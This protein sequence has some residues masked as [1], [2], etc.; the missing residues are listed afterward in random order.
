MGGPDQEIL[1]VVT[2]KKTAAY[3]NFDM[4][5]MKNREIIHD[6]MTYKSTTVLDIVDHHPRAISFISNGAA[7]NNP[8]IKRLRIDGLSP[9]DKNYP[10]SQTFSFVTR[11]N[12][13]GV[14]KQ[15]IDFA[16]SPEGCAII[17]D[18]GMIPVRE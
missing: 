16:L 1:V 15:F 4:L 8:C 13:S 18:R 6:C 2:R 10:Y 14:V 3:R 5:V 7:I 11:G 9:G 12:P 17:R